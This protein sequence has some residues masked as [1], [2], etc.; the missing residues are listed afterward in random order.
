MHHLSDAIVWPRCPKCAKMMLLGGID[1]ERHGRETWIFECPHAGSG[2]AWWSN[3]NRNAGRVPI[4]K[5]RAI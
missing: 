4:L 2:K 3:A 1:F 5:R